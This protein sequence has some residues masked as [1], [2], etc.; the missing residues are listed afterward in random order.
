M[1][2]LLLFFSSVLLSIN[3]FS[4]VLTIDFVPQC[5]NNHIQMS[6]EQIFQALDS[7][8]NLYH[9]ESKYYFFTARCIKPNFE[10]NNPDKEYLHGIDHLEN[11][12]YIWSRLIIKD[13]DLGWKRNIKSDLMEYLYD[14]NRYEI[15]IKPQEQVD[16]KISSHQT[17]V[18]FSDADGPFYVKQASNGK[19]YLMVE[20]S[21]SEYRE[22]KL[23]SHGNCSYDLQYSSMMIKLKDGTVKTLTNAHPL[24]E[25][26][27]VNGSC[28]HFT[29]QFDI[30]SVKVADIVK[31][32]LIDFTDKYDYNNEY[33][34]EMLSLMQSAAIENYKESK[35]QDDF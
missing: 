9:Y 2:Q 27:C 6:D 35:A 24:H 28:H 20:H 29:D 17:D 12:L 33:I 16:Y 15:K 34:G 13:K 31:I 30:T 1:K 11:G 23:V 25:I 4:E 32:R 5:A 19:L 10:S 7:L 22:A 26:D 14:T 3:C 18:G 21:D 8:K